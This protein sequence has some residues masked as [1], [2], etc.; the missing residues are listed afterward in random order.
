MI[1]SYV[2]GSQRLYVAAGYHKWGLSTG[3]F[4][5][6]ILAD[7]I[8]GK[9]NDWTE[10][11]SPHRITLGGVPKLAKMNA[12]VAVDLVGDRLAP[13][14]TGTDDLP[15]GHGT[16]VR[17]GLGR[18]AVYRDDAGTLHAVSA[19]CTHLGCLVRFNQAERSWD[20]PCHGSRFDADGHVL[21]GPATKPLPP[22]TL[23]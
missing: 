23:G 19:R 6:T 22:R 16:I 11:F 5:A 20:C 18:T 13:A 12:K 9:P 7:L 8:T 10:R 17:D 1:G 15:P 4:A 2:P 21:E 3:T 14:S